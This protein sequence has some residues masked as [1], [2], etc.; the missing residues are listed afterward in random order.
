MKIY[1][2]MV[3]V[4]ILC[5]MA[6][7]CGKKDR[8]QS[9]EQF[10]DEIEASL[11]DFDN[12][13]RYSSFSADIL[14]SIP[15]DRLEMAIIDYI[16]DI[17]LKENYKEEY[18]ITKTLSKGMQYIYI[19][20]ELDGEVNNGGFIQYFYNSSGV[21]AG[22]LIEALHNIKAFKTEKI[23][24]EAITV[25]NKER[26]L[27]EKVKKDGSIESFISSYGESELGRLDELFYKSGEDLSIL[28]ISYIRSN[29]EQFITE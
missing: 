13:K 9:D 22:D 8:H 26:T 29:P 4:V 16:T 18:H 2:V 15:D 27:H 17:R 1:R 7:S 20:W 3:L 12:R 24:A 11:K 25:Y 23:A 10:G 6:A 5:T 21:F 14:K 28:R 19:T